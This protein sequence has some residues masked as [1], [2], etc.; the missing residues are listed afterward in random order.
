MKPK[1]K[2]LKTLYILIVSIDTQEDVDKLINN[3]KYYT[4]GEIMIFNK[5]DIKSINLRETNCSYYFLIPKEVTKTQ[6]WSNAFKEVEIENYSNF[7]FSEESFNIECNID[8][9]LRRSKC[10]NLTFI[11]NKEGFSEYLFSV[12]KEDIPLFINELNKEDAKIQD[13]Y[14]K[15]NFISLWEEKSTENDDEIILEYH[16]IDYDDG[17]DFSLITEE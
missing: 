1:I 13:V 9:F 4:G 8:Q 17:S 16:M 6:I 14:K 11:K 15:M 7:V 2:E 12:V 3:T 10:K 5:G